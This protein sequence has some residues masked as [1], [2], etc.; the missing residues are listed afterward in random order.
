MT[1]PIIDRAIAETRSWV[2]HAVVGLN[3]CPFAKVP[4]AGDR[5]RF[6]C[7]DVQDPAALRDV[8][9]AEMQRLVAADPSEIE[10]TLLI[11]PR[12][13]RDFL[14]FNDFLDVADDALESLELDGVLQVA[15]FHPDYQFAGS[16]G[17]DL[18]NATNRS[19]YPT[20][21]LLREASVGRAVDRVPDIEAIVD[22]NL[23]TLTSLGSEG[24]AAL[25]RRWN[26]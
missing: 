23:E 12:V 17:D 24:W 1:D 19:P 20:L 22:A 8:L 14:D 11:H 2:E 3:L 16:A 9:V 10:T 4:L 5:V 7:T 6:V 15:S 26:G 13:L 18:G 21:Q 25:R